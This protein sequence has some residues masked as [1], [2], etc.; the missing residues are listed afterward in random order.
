M[1]LRRK[2]GSPDE[3]RDTLSEQTG[4]VVQ[5]LD[6]WLWFTRAIKT[7]T[8]A[9]TLIEAG[10][11]RVNSVKVTKPSHTVQPGDV[12][13][14]SVQKDVRILRVNAI[15]LR[16][17]PAAEAQMLYEDLTPKPA[18][19]PNSQADPLRRQA[20]GQRDAGSGRP[21]KRDRRLIDRLRD[22]D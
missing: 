13:T 9:A 4:P 22:G 21:T 1:T 20:S 10:K 18:A 14:S 5:R 16:R 8:L 15:G 17:G 6:R 3:G 11:I 2:T 7:R 12:V 19:S